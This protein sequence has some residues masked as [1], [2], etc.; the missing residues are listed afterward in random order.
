MQKAPLVLFPIAG[1]FLLPSCIARKFNATDSHVTDGSQAG[2]EIVIAGNATFLKV[3]K[4]DSSTLELGSQK[5]VLAKDSKI[6]LLEPF[7]EDGYHLVVKLKEKLEGCGFS[8]GY[9]YSGHVVHQNPDGDENVREDGPVGNRRICKTGGDG[10]NF[11]A[12]PATT[13]EILT[14]VV[15]DTAITLTGKVSGDFIQADITLDGKGYKGWVKTEFVCNLSASGEFNSTIASSFRSAII[16]G[17]QGRNYGRGD[18]Y[19]YVW[20]ALKDVLG[21]HIES[22]PV[23]ITS[24][25][26]FGDWV[27]ANPETA[28]ASMKLVRGKYTRWNAPV[29][30]MFVWNRGQGGYNYKHGHIEIKIN[31]S[32]ACSDGCWPINPSGPEPRVYIPVK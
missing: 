14:P 31:D 3:S 26:Q 32:T 18:C 7:V 29:G 19:L 10:V 24:A 22:L 13:S 8:E 11:R 28:R 5:C 25:Y 2:I 16:V 12:G 30:S 17:T 23:P 6:A 21:S 27:D 1:L 4:D 20:T 9:V 15:D